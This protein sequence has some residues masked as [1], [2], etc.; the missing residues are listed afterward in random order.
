I[1][2]QLVA[3]K[4]PYDAETP[5]AVILKHLNEP[6]PAL[7]TIK[8]DTPVNI[9]KLVQKAMAK[10]PQERFQNADELLAGLSALSEP[11]QTGAIQAAPPAPPPAGGA[12]DTASRR[13]SGDE[14]PPSLST[15]TAIRPP[16]RRSL[17]G[18]GAVAVVG[19]LVL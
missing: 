8:P 1:F 4:L 17:A 10:D 12:D 5:L 11:G 14:E 9:E 3:G 13:P 15:S 16:R 18:V 7:R 6:V 2:F 19:L